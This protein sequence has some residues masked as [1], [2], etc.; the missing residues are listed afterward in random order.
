MR[1]RADKIAGAAHIKRHTKGTSNEISLSV[2]DAAK[3]AKE[4]E[5]RASE[6]KARLP[7]LGSIPLFTLGRVKKPVATPVKERGLHLSTGEF[8]SAEDGQVKG[9]STPQTVPGIAVEGSAAAGGGTTAGIGGMA[10]AA[11]GVS[12]GAAG[13]SLA[14]TAGATRAGASAGGGI[15]GGAGGASGALSDAA[16]AGLDAAGGLS[17]NSSSGVSQKGT[18]SS[19]RSDV[20][21]P[22]W[23]TPFE[24]VAR[25]KANRKRRRRLALAGMS[26][27]VTLLLAV[28][29]ATLYTGLQMQQ[30]KKSQLIDCIRQIE[31]TDGIILP[32]D[33]LVIRASSKPLE[34]LADEGFALNGEGQQASPPD[35]SLSPSADGASPASD[36]PGAALS[37]ASSDASSATSSGAASDTSDASNATSQSDAAAASSTTLQPNAA[38]AQALGAMQLEEAERT[39]AE[40]KRSV[41]SLQAG[42]VDNDI[43]EAANQALISINARLNMIQSGS[44]AL[45]ETLRV[46]TPFD[47]AQKGW[48]LILQGDA[49]A[50]AAAALVAEIS[51]DNVNAS[52]EKSNEAIGLFSQAREQLVE[53]Q[54]GYEVELD[55]FLYYIDLRI[56]SQ[57]LALSSDQAY[58]DRDKEMLAEANEAYNKADAEAVALIKEQKGNPQTLVSERFEQNTQADFDSYAADR[59]RAA[60][61]D[62]FLR[63][64][65]GSMGK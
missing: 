30:D 39:L 62:A 65:L 34:Q 12:A 26:L 27:V 53:A 45:K 16:S 14:G 56:E 2:L 41:E 63:D 43:K 36:A 50:R 33:D 48:D 10:A 32:F 19:R 3:A 42:V 51:A 59:A 58:L 55:P 23:E 40:V 35:G 24:E 11:G 37:S 61:A 13:A 52:M 31:E 60:A 49:A 47:H 25:R 18:G 28:G 1:D 8:V 5:A 64:Y 17:P 15:A 20:T 6:P 9:S 44:A 38:A 54:A 21:A 4:A 29:A 22:A 7:R 46:L 57:R